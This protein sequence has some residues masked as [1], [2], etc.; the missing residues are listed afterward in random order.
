MSSRRIAV[1]TLSLSAA[2]LVAA[3]AF[4]S[5]AAEIRSLNDGRVHGFD[6][7][8]TREPTG[9]RYFDLTNAKSD[10]GKNLGTAR[11]T[12]SLYGIQP[13]DSLN[14]RVHV[15][16]TYLGHFATDP[17]SG[18]VTVKDISISGGQCS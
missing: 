17:G 6:G 2:A 9:I 4:P 8:L 13:N 16:G 7:C 12:G 3:T 5:F 10:D 18:H 11:L 15:N 14:H 1:V